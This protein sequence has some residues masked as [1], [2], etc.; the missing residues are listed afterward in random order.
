[1]SFRLPRY[2]RTSKHSL[3]VHFL[4]QGKNLHEHVLFSASAHWKHLKLP[5]DNKRSQWLTFNKLK[6]LG[7]TDALRYITLP[8]HLTVANFVASDLPA[9]CPR[10][11][12]LPVQHDALRKAAGRYK[13]IASRAARETTLLLTLHETQDKIRMQKSLR[14]HPVKHRLSVRSKNPTI[15]QRPRSHT[16]LQ[17]FTSKRFNPI[18][19]SDSNFTNGP[20]GF[21]S[22]FFGLS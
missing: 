18:R 19:L 20:L 7:P 1:M 8:G 10:R 9:V 14:F 5:S 6:K 21:P 11:R 16:C 2:L 17:K 22:I 12:R 4:L 15:R 3:C 13:G